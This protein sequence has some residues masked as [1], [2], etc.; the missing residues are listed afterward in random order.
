MQPPMTACRRILAALGLACA[1]ATA[2]PAARA[3]P[4][5]PLAPLPAVP[6]A[7]APG[8]EAPLEK[9]L[10]HDFAKTPIFPPGQR[11][12]VAGAPRSAPP[13]EGP[14]EGARLAIVCLGL[15]STLLAAYCA[16]RMKGE[17]SQTREA[18]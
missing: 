11:L 4:D 16:I 2:Q 13:A 6:Q 14:S 8:L 12:V 15:G 7:S 17:G 5:L 9:P 10:G 18:G 1:A 3:A